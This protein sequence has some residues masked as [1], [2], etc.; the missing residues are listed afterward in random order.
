MLLAGIACKTEKN[1]DR[2]IHKKNSEEDPSIFYAMKETGKD[3]LFA[4]YFNKAG[5]YSREGLYFKAGVF[6]KKCDSMKP[7]NIIVLNSLGIN[8]GDQKNTSKAEQYFLQAL[9]IDSTYTT[10]YMNFGVFYNQ[11]KK[12]TKAI[13]LFKKGLSMEN[14]WERKG[15][16]NYNI[17]N[18][19]AKLEQYKKSYF[20]NEQALEIITEPVMRKE[21]I[22]LK[23]YVDRKLRN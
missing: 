23:K 14:N 8:A 9:K 5:F 22:E 6:L 17:A 15:Y 4:V 10:T 12:S 16:F 11:N 7:N 1:S 18:A 20:H 3:S 21:I 2:I 13:K 19:Y